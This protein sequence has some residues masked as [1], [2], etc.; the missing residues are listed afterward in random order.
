VL[1]ALL[2][3][4]LLLLCSR[5]L[6]LSVCMYTVQWHICASA[7]QKLLV[8]CV[9]CVTCLRGPTAILKNHELMIF[10]CVLP[11]MLSLHSLS[12]LSCFLH[13][14]SHRF[15]SLITASSLNQVQYQSCYDLCLSLSLSN[16]HVHTLY[17][18]T[19]SYLHTQAL[20]PTTTHTHPHAYCCCSHNHNYSYCSYYYIPIT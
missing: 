10:W 2:T 20:Q 4:L 9:T 13:C 19:P 11:E 8:L 16:T 3:Y 1:T 18:N 7:H 12:K 6:T 17:I 14:N 15:T 5:T